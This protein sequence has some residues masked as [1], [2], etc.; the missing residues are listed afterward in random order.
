[1]ITP[2]QSG[3]GQ[4]NLWSIIK[5]GDLDVIVCIFLRKEPL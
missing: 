5:N 3:L 4:S 2:Q 1:M